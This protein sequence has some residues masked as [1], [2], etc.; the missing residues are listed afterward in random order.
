MDKEIQLLLDISFELKMTNFYF[1][2]F[3]MIFNTDSILI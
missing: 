3:S 2:D 1:G